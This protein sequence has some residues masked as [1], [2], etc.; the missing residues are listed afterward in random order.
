MSIS[1][2]INIEKCVLERNVT[3]IYILTQNVKLINKY[4]YY[5]LKYYNNKIIRNWIHGCKLYIY[6][7]SFFR[8]IY[9]LLKY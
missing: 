1:L 3:F 5:W 9:I 7:C 6:A 4:T 8:I 2:N